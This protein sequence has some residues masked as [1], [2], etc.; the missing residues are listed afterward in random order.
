MKAWVERVGD[1]NGTLK[2]NA[3]TR[4]RMNPKGQNPMP[5]SRPLARRRVHYRHIPERPLPGALPTAARGARAAPRA[6]PWSLPWSRT[7]QHHSPMAEAYTGPLASS[8]SQ[9]DFSS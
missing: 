8:A 7:I 6:G 4:K 5:R 2:A 9:D 1:E 3:V